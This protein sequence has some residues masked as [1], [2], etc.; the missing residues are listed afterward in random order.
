MFLK[1]HKSFREKNTFLRRHKTDKLEYM[2]R[3]FPDNVVNKND[4]SGM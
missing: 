2:S 3:N 1:M 4:F